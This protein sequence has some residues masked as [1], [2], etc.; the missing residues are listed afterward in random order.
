[1]WTKISNY[2]QKLWEDMGHNI[3]EQEILVAQMLNFKESKVLMQRLLL[4]IV[5]HHVQYSTWWMSCE[6]QP[7]FAKQLV[8]KIFAI[9]PHSASCER[10]FSA[11][12]WLYGKEEQLWIL[13]Q[14]SP[15]PNFGILSKQY[16]F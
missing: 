6:D 12:G 13:V 14:L 9:T 1:M 11:L 15:W 8:L 5:L 10:M 2:A 4:K 7:P 16:A 3:E